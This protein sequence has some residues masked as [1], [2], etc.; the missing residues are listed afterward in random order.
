MLIVV[1]EVPVLVCSPKEGA[2]EGMN[3]MV[4]PNLKRTH[5][6]K[7]KNLHLKQ[8]SFYFLPSFSF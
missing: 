5:E 2:L 3:L 1:G 4:F 7:N 8:L 6:Y